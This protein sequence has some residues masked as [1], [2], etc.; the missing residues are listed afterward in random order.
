[1]EIT[2]WDKIFGT[3]MEADEFAAQCGFPNDNENR[4]WDMLKFKDVYNK[5]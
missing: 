2:W 5:H 3:F 4:I 1:M